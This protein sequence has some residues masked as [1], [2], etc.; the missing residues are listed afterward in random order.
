[1]AKYVI[2]GQK[3]LSG[4]VRI[5]GSKNAALPILAATLLTPEECVIKNVPDIRDTHTMLTLME[6]LGSKVSFSNNTVTIQTPEIQMNELS[7]KLAC[8]MRASVLLLG[9]ILARIGHAQL[10]YP[11]GC[12]LGARPLDT[13]V[14]VFRSLKVEEVDANGE[15]MISLKGFPQAG[16]IVMPEM[17]VTGT[18]NAIMAAALA[19]GQTSIRLAAVE[20][21]V[22]D[23]CNFINKLGGHI[24]GIGTHTI[25]VN[26]EKTLHG[27]EY[28]IT[29]DYLETGTFALAAFLTGGDVKLL[30]IVPS[31]LD[32]FWNLLKKMGGNFTL[33][34]TWAHIK[35]TASWKSCDRLQTNVFPGFP[36]DLQPP[37]AILLTQAQGES[38]IH[39]AL[40]EG[41]FAYFAELAKMGASIKT[42]SD[43]QATIHGPTPLKA[44]EVRSCD[45][46]A[47][48]AMILAGLCAEGTTTVTDI[49]Y[50]DR[51]YEQ[52][53]S[54]LRALG[55][56]I[57]RIKDVEETAPCAET[58]TS[59]RP[60][61]SV[62]KT[63]AP[64]PSSRLS[65]SAL[66]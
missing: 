21:H 9:P 53:D 61:R 63:V 66:G 52:F 16:L 15:A 37:F 34:D 26:G 50:I 13:H 2:N 5:G 62:R 64:E 29:P 23:L 32:P 6:S 55:A 33:G 1:M 51:G 19:H 11:G 57:Q 24:T 60:A 49:H 17:S 40:F 30:D 4:E 45:I 38:Y 42:M 54:K 58:V 12:V 47:G 20:P 7:D 36:T 28:T 65:T 31:H 39:E 10:P 35:P 18:E 27:A 14:D 44:A 56:D 3:K 46:R 48:A 25:N 59:T 43:H 8:Q 22:Q 41:R